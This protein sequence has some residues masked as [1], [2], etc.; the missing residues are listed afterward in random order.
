[1]GREVASDPLV[2]ALLAARDSSRTILRCGDGF[3][4][5]VV[6]RGYRFLA[7]VTSSDASGHEALRSV[8]HPLDARA[9]R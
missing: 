3:I 1:V 8:T 7:N 4:E 6:G 2:G 9:A 5:T